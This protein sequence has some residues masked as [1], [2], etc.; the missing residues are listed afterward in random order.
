MSASR[1]GLYLAAAAYTLW[2]AFPIYFKQL[3]G[4]SADEILAHRI[5]WSV[6]FLASVLL[7]LKRWA[8]IR[9]AVTSKKVMLAFA[10]SALLLSLNWLIYIW[11]VNSNHVVDSSLGYFIN[12]LVSILLGQWVFKERLRAMQWVAVGIATVGV[13]WLTWDAGKLPW[14]GLSL[15]VTFGLY[16]LMRKV[17]PLGAL[18]GLALETTL[19]VPLALGWLA[20]LA[21]Q[22][23]GA[24]STSSTTVSLL[25]LA[26]GPITAIPL[27]L[28]AA[29][30]RRISMA[31]L[32][33]MQYIAPSLQFAAGTLLYNEAV[34]G[35]KL[36][37][38]IIIWAALA[39]YTLE[40][41]WSQR[42]AA[43]EPA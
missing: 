20:W 33:F 27:I 23:P 41:L 24:L 39:V 18:E 3:A 38:F 8:W 11:A 14:I 21:T 36:T 28:F 10:A 15:A 12:P 34:T 19:L 17:A 30:A 43:S 26:S 32:G 42:V 4:I 37:G 25:L 22:Q 35:G 7:A 9:A 1:N 6:A 5:V 31:N 40:S 16:G 29:G 13:L 2:G